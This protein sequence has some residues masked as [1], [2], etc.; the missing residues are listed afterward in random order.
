[1]LLAQKKG[2]YCRGKPRIRPYHAMF[3]QKILCFCKYF[4]VSLSAT[5]VQGGA[6]QNLMPPL[7]FYFLFIFTLFE[8]TDI[9][10]SSSTR[11]V[12]DALLTEPRRT[13]EEP[14]RTSFLIFVNAF[15]WHAT[16]R[17]T[18]HLEEPRRTLEEPSAPHS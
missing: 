11:S 7:F 16:D 8:Q 17:A 2:L 4:L 5:T 15:S 3:V 14:R 18:P 1:M 13:L 10:Y 12:A 9:Y 6:L